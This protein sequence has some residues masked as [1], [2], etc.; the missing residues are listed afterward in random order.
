[1][2]LQACRVTEKEQVGSAVTRPGRLPCTRSCRHQ[3]SFLPMGFAT[4]M[5]A[6]S[7]TIGTS[8]N[9]LVVG[10]TRNILLHNFQGSGVSTAL[11]SY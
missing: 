11:P 10:I 1:M 6:M 2:S 7:T 3:D 9:L 8:P 5:G 4:L